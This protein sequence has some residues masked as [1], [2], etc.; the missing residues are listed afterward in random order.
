MPTGGILRL[1]AVVEEFEGEPH[2][3]LAVRD[4]GQGMSPDQ[5]DNL[6]A[7]S[8]PQGFGHRHRPRHRQ[9]NHGEPQSKVQVESKVGQGTK[10]KLLFPITDPHAPASLGEEV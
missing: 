6:F 7:P 1:S 8:S 4:N 5:I 2:L 3:A 10:F 9:K